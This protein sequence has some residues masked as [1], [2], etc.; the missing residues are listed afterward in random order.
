MPASDDRS[1]RIDPARLTYVWAQV[2]DDLRADIEAGT[3]RPGDKL[4]AETD[5]AGR[6]G[7]ARMTVRRA[8]AELASEGLVVVM[9]GRGTFVAQ[10]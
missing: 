10:A 8:V 7:V 6:Y 4:P 2:A 1:G 5:L 3:L 9:H